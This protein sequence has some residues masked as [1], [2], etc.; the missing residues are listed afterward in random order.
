MNH[1][2]VV[3]C[4]ECGRVEKVRTF[5]KSHYAMTYFNNIIGNDDEWL[6]VER[7]NMYCHA[8]LNDNGDYEV[9]LCWEIMDAEVG[10]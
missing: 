3:V 9:Y 5:S 7:G 8:V 6:Y 4:V 1:T 2:W 10:N